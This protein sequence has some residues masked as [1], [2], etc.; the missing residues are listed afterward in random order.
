MEM[1]VIA[2]IRRGRV[3]ARSK[4]PVDDQLSHEKHY[5]FYFLWRPKAIQGVMPLGK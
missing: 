5:L 4:K 1:A 2:L 3:I